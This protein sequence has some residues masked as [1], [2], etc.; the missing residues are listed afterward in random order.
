MTKI[1]RLLSGSMMVAA[2]VATPAS[3]FA[4]TTPAAG[5][6]T[7]PA[8]NL[9]VELSELLGAHAILA[10]LAMQAGYSGNSDYVALTSA[11]NQNTQQ[12]GAAVASVYGQAAGQAFDKMW[13]GHIQDFVNY[14]VATKDHNAAGKAA[15]LTA[16]NQYRQQFSA[17]MAKADPYI[18]ANTLSQSLQVHVKQLIATFNAYVAGNYSQSA[19]DF[20]SAYNHMFMDGD[21][22][23]TAITEQYPSKFGDSNPN[24]PAVNLRITLDQL[25]GSH[26]A[27]AQLAMETAYFG[28]PDAVSWGT[29]LSRNTQALSGAIASVYGSTA[30]QQFDKMWSAHIQDFVNYVIATKNHDS[31]GQQ[32]ALASL[33]AY[34]VH[35]AKFLA[36]ANPNYNA[37][38][39]EDALQVHVNQLI[40]TFNDFAAKNPTA[41]I[42]AY[43]TA[44]NHM[45]MAGDY[46]AQGIV[47]QFPAKFGVTMVNNATSPVTGIPFI[48]VM[49]FGAALVAG[50]AALWL[51]RGATR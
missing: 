34:K 3:A 33:A 37:T 45:F 17:F 23:A 24:T 51:R 46:L 39:L 47:E 25:L 27:L 48:P 20:V 5:A 40:A 10:Q 4:A 9:R 28:S 42:P 6:T 50:G 15:A 35:F 21:Y 18:N 14:V 26:A 38:T 11:L 22:F 1:L 29:V 43:V 7:T 13:S 36:S 30:G 19:A 49:A 2:L 44:Y 31:A 8:A 16:L 32:S 41:A 12:L